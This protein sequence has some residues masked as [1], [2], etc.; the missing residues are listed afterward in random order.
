MQKAEK[1]GFIQDFH[2]LDLN[3]KTEIVLEEYTKN[4][5]SLIIIQNNLI[6]FYFVLKNDKKK[7]IEYF[8][9]LQ[10][11]YFGKIIKNI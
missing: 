6:K 2:A 1:N 7:A 5:F 3:I 8:N 9:E 10:I 11:K 4:R